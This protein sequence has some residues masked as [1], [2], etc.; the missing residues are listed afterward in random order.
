M[1]DNR[2]HDYFAPS[3]TAR[4]QSLLDELVASSRLE[5]QAAARRLST[6]TELFEL[7]RAERGENPDW[8]VDT[9]AAVGAEVAAALR[10]SLGKAGSY[11]N[12]GLAMQRLP[13]LATLFAAG[14][15]DMNIFRTL[16]YRTD[17]ITNET[18]LAEVDRLLAA[19]VARWPSMTHGQLVR[20]IDRIVVTH[21]RDAV[22]RTKERARD[23][24]VTIW[25]DA[26]GMSDVSA[27]LFTADAQV[28]DKRL[29]ALAA[30]VCVNDPRTVEQ[31]RAD[32]LGALAANA[33]R[34]MCRCGNPDCPSTATVPSTVVI[35][36]VAEQST[37]NGDSDRPGYLMG[38]DALISAELLRDLAVQAR[39][40]SLVHPA[41]AP[42]EPRYQPSR[43][44]ADFVRARDLTCRAPGC[45]R[46]ATACDL[47][48]TVPYDS[49]GPTHA[50]NLKCLCRIHHLLKTFWGWKDRQ[51]Q[52]GTIIWELPG[53]K[54]HI[55]TPGSALLFPSL[56]AP[57]GALPTAR[58][59]SRHPDR[60][61]MMPLRKTTRARNRA[62]C[63]ATERAHNRQLRQRRNARLAEALNVSG[64][65]NDDGDDP[66]F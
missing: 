11:M 50:S 37:L 56:V 45:D 49:G 21:D 42:A 54:T 6:I 18:A 52:D 60:T 13:V 5:N 10:I 14:D 4:S 44:L 8:A 57:T 3:D 20:E 33:E 46:P 22:R 55:T 41:N 2:V 30:T 25:T 32:A 35:H 59:L 24:D 34:L 43:A 12:Y 65:P 48:H 39:R 9:W 38:A 66:P 23:R 58:H 47:D 28:L 15:I 26:G 51:L 1:F 40:R 61:A 29:D 36:V 31:R 7:R 63:I 62:H 27:R 53:G 64:L 19:R 16:V 17:L